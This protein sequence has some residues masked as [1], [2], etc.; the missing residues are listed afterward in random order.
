[1]A[2]TQLRMVVEA[3]TSSA[4]ASLDRTGAA[5]EDAGDRV[6]DAGER[7]GRGLDRMSQGMGEAEDKA[8]GFAYMLSGAAG[9]GLGFSQVMQGDV[10]AG[11]VMMAMGIADLAQGIAKFAIPAIKAM[12]LENIKSTAVKVKDT[13]ATVANKVAS[14]A[15]AAATKAMAA[16][17]WVLNAAMRANPI[18][19][20]ITLIAALVAGIIYAYRHSETFRRIVDTGL[21]AVSAAFK[22]LWSAAGPVLGW[23]WD[24]M[25]KLGN[26]VKGP[27]VAA[28]K[29]MVNA[30]LGYFGM[31]INGAAKLLGWVPGLGPKLQTAAREFN[32]FR[33]N[34][35]RALDG[36]NDETVNV[37]VRTVYSGGA[38][39]YKKV[40]I[41]PGMGGR[42]LGGPVVPG[43]MYI[44][45]EEGPEIL[46]LTGSPV[47]G[48]VH[49]NR[50]SQAVLRG[51]GGGTHIHV[52]T[53]AVI[54][55]DRDLARLIDQAMTRLGRSGAYV[56]R[57]A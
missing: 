32:K 51:V 23:I 52:H 4:E 35:N 19:I 56:P 11:T 9:V 16:A 39:Y 25:T 44:V 53:P 34:V 22:A 7:S 57:M 46:D 21:K 50:D 12:T 10:F 33:D 6:E 37:N 26:A 31:I 40:A 48:Y 47:G 28:F 2:D 8:E 29:F 13:A 1:M 54:T 38:E 45:G 24:A 15:S 41:N 43:G 20:V 49:N 18:G 5:A 42:A 3:D 14:V 36:I 17:Q 30:V 55:G 27:I